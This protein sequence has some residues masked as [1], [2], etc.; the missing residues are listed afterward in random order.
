MTVSI[1]FSGGDLL[2]G[3][4]ILSVEDAEWLK[5]IHAEEWRAAVANGHD[6]ACR[7]IHAVRLIEIVAVLFQR[8]RWAQSSGAVR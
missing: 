4:D 6:R 8:E 7:K 5:G 1:T 2:L 3:D